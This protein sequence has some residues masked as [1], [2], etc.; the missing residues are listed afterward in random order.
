VPLVRDARREALITSGSAMSCFC[1][2]ADITRWFSTSQA[3]SSVSSR[4]SPCSVPKA[5][6][7]AAPS[8]E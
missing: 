4:E 2:V 1:A 6:A 8:W 3:I 5:A 7:S